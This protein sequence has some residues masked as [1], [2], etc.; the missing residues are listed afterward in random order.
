M[1][2]LLG[3]ALRRCQRRRRFVWVQTDSAATVEVLGCLSADVRRAGS[4]LRRRHGKRAGAPDTV[5]EYDVKVTWGTGLAPSGF[6]RSPR[7]ALSSALAPAS[8]H[9]L[10]AIFGSCRYPKT[11]DEKV[12]SKLGL[13]ALDVY[14]TRMAT[15]PGSMTGRRR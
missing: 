3:P 13:D 2:L 12:D 9:R 15:Q 1:A 8:T 11:D 10:Q 5:T 14:A 4:S 7:R 6:T